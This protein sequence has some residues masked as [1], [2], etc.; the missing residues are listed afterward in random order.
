MRTAYNDFLSAR[1]F[2]GLDGLRCLSIVAV[3]AYHVAAT[4]EGLIGRGYLGVALF[5]AISGFLITTLLLRERDKVGRISLRGFF[6]RRSLR[7]FPLYYAVLGLYAVVVFLAEKDAVVRGDFFS[8]L[9]AFLTYTSNWF[10]PQHPDKRVIFYFA[11]S[12]ATEE[13]FYL[14]WPLVIRLSRRAWVPVLFMCGLLTAALGTP[15]LVA[16]GLLDGGLL[17]V[18]MLSSLSASICM[19]CLAAYVVHSPRGFGLVYPVLGQVWSVPALMGVLLGVVAWHDAPAW[20]TSLTMVS[21]VVATCIRAQQP[22]SAPMSHPWVRYI[23]TVSYGIYLLHMLVLNGVRR[24]VPGQGTA[25]Q[26]VLTLAL[27]VLVAGLSYRYFESWFL[28][29]KGRFDWRGHAASEAP[30]TAPAETP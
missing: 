6:A 23:G 29:L 14:M 7:I 8:N 10:V 17:G 30:S 13:Q 26:F 27:S 12:L 21:L 1:F 11:W 28:K 22:L 20:L 24:A 16:Q 19:G 25:V 15:V 2:A 9:P 18:R 3:V 4:H 5:F